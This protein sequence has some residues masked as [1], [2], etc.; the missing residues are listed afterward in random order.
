ML[1]IRLLGEFSLSYGGTPVAAVNTARLQSLL[2]FL[3]I[4]RDAPQPRHHLASLFWP[5]VLE[6]QARN[7]LRQMLHQLRHALPDADSFVYADTNTLRWSTDIPFSL[8]VAEFE[9]AL[10][11][12]ES[13]SRWGD[14]N[15]QRRA[16]EEAVEQYRGDLLPGCYEDWIEPERERLRQSM[17]QALSELVHLLEAQREYAAAIRHARAWVRHDPLAEDAYRALMHVLALS[18]DRAGA[19]RAYHTCVT[20]L[21][22]ELGVEPSPATRELHERLLTMESQPMP[23]A[24][25]ERLLAATPAFVGRQHEW[26]RLRAIWQRAA[27]GQPHVVLVSGEAGIGKS[28]LAEEF[29]TWA[30]RQGVVV[31]RTRSYAAEGQLSLAPVT[32]WLRSDGIRPHLAQIDPIWLAEVARILPEL[33]AEHR[34]L[35]RPEPIAEYGQRQRFFEALARAILA[36]PQ[37]LVL[38]LDDLQWCDQETLEWLHFLMRFDPLAR[39][40]VVGT[41]RSE[42]LPLHHPLRA[43]LLHLGSAEGMTEIALQPLDAAEVA[44]LAAQVTGREL[45]TGAVLRLFRETEG[46]PLFV[47]ETMRAG[48]PTHDQPSSPT[49]ADGSTA[50]A[51]QPSLPPRVYAVIAGRLARLSP[52]AREL[53][54]LAAAIGRAFTLD[55]LLRAGNGDEDGTV[56]ALDELWNKRIVREQGANSYD[57]SHDKLREV[58]YAEISPPQRRLLHRRIAQ[59][60]ESAHADD[61]DAVSG[62]IAAHYEQAGMVEQAIPY[63]QRAAAVAQRIYANDD[64]I[65][66]LSRALTL[67][68]SLPAGMKRGAQELTLLLALARSLRVARGWAEP[69]LERVLDRAHALSETIGDDVQRWQVLFGLQTLYAVQAKLEKTRY[70]S[71]ELATLYQRAYGTEPPRLI[72]IVST[73]ALL[74]LGHI[75]EANKRF[76]AVTA[77]DILEQAQR[78][79]EAQGSNYLLHAWAWQSHALWCL[80]YPQAALNRCDEAVRLARDLGQPFNQALAAAYLALLMQLCADHATA[81]EHAEE[82]LALASEYRAPYY[83]SWSAILVEYARAWEQPDAENLTRLRDAI[84]AFTATGARIRLPYYLSLLARTYLKAGRAR[85]GLAVLDE[86]LDASRTHNERWWDAELHRLRGEL[87]LAGGADVQD[88]E[89]ALLR[90][91]QIARSQEARSLELRAAISLTRLWRTQRRTGDGRHL[92]QDLCDWFTE[93]YDMPDLQEARSLL[94]RG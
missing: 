68:E 52:P 2:A 5:D 79:E 45:D 35:P 58:A 88:V 70:L 62:Q 82:A 33:S 90:S 87:L 44:H 43:L 47:V 15:E 78:L 89:A 21:R 25:H 72:E 59:A 91:L 85:D 60:V 50:L 22:R 24:E 83:R 37:P 67:L 42:E 18:G 74:H 65:N 86:A 30:G 4:H 36:A 28:R 93:G 75:Q 77:D 11:R 10:A 69:E 20:A 32:E 9:L 55:T 38:L 17:L 29:L 84:A 8:D 6:G 13:S 16:L 54:G 94:A 39:L 73:G 64:A 46:V 48:G 12:A 61:L 53:A 40:L 49:L 41:A 81:R 57:F 14:R 92:L 7:N 56:R 3:L 23:P 1:Q 19:L 31:A 80:G 27:A 66:L 26:E 34:D 51:D 71:G 76:A 63:Y